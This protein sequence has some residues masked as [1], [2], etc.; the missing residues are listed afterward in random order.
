MEEAQG[1]LAIRIV[2]VVRQTQ[3]WDENRFPDTVLLSAQVRF[4]VRDLEREKE[5][6]QT[7]MEERES[8]NKVSEPAE[9]ESAAMGRLWNRVCTNVVRATLEGFY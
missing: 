3:T 5:L 4:L 6:L 1:V 8:Y 9:D 2:R 7:E